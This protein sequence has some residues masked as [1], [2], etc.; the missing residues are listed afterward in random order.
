M[1]SNTKQITINRSING[2]ISDIKKTEE[3]IKKTIL[4]RFLDI[5]IKQTKEQENNNRILVMN[6]KHT[7]NKINK[8]LAT[9]QTSLNMLERINN[10]KS[11]ENNIMDTKKQTDVN[12][13]NKARGD[14]ESKWET[15]YDPKY[16]KYMKEDTMNNRMMERLNS[17]IDFRQ[18][19]CDKSEIEK[20][21]DVI[22]TDTETENTTET[23]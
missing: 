17:E 13:L 5:K 8:I 14:N 21:F 7:D 18:S 6:K 23:Y 11:K 20:P 22:N 15:S 10:I 1:T 2:L 12:I 19:D 4:Q 3:P 9:Q 16:A